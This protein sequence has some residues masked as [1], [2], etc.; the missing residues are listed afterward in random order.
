MQTKKIQSHL[1][2]T[3]IN[4]QI[5]DGMVHPTRIVILVMAI[6]S[7]CIKMMCLNSCTSNLLLQLQFLT[8]SVVCIQINILAGAYIPQITL[9]KRQQQE[10]VNVDTS[11][12]YLAPFLKSTEGEFNQMAILD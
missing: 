11:Y 6:I 2:I 5:S 8:L 1:S 10:Y 12:F 3:T 7:I 4:S 9:D